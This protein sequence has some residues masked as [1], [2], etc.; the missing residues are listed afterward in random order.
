LF[1]PETIQKMI[2]HWQT[3]LEA[4]AADSEQHIADLPLLTAAEREQIL[5]E[6]NDTK[7]NYPRD[8]CLHELIEG[9][10]QLTPTAAA[11]ACEHKWLSYSELNA[12]ANQ[13]AHHL[14]KLGV[15][16]EVLVGVCMDRSLD[17]MIVLLG[18]MKAGGAYVPLDPAYPK[19]RLEFMIADSGLR[20]IICDSSSSSGVPEFAE[21]PICID[22]HWPTVFLESKQALSTEVQPES[23][24]YVI[25]TS[26]STGRPK[27]VQI[28]HSALVNLVKSMQRRLGIDQHDRLLAVTTISFDIA[29]LEL[30][31]PLTVGA[32]CVIAG[33][34]AAAD[35]YQ[36]FKMF[37][38]FKITAMQATPST[39]KLLLESGWTGKATLKALCGG[40]AMPRELAAQLL[41]RV[42]SVWNMYGPTE[43]TVWSSVH[44]AASVKEAV[45]IGR[46]IDNTE[47]YVLDRN[48]QPLPSG[49][50]GELFIGGDGLARGYLNRPDLEAE[51]FIPNPFSERP[52]ARLYKT[53]DLARYRADGNIE[54]LGRVDNQVKIRGFRVELGEIESVL[55]AHLAITD[56]CV[57]VREDVPGDLRLVA[58]LRLVEKQTPPFADIHN[59]LKERLPGYMIPSLVELD[60]FPLTPNGKLDRLALPVPDAMM[61]MQGCLSEMPQDPIEQLLAATWRELLRVQHIST[62]DNFFDLGGHSLLATQVVAR[63]E[64]EIGLRMKPKEL[65]FQTLGQFAA[66]CKERL[67]RQ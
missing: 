64:K 48:L 38:D 7:V 57:I 10:V 65:A 67:K 26:G 2:G 50:I 62:Y 30:Y 23:L 58:Y 47:I 5:V 15:G 60:G 25:Y 36:L 45:F 39:W 14:R 12:R 51:R 37:E 21:K 19:A 44:R 1:D 55:R 35:G 22:Q 66:S 16:P 4:A 13:L 41:A 11:V 46:P 6:W 17:M 32:C 61:P 9:Q 56:A 63:L 59:F 28:S 52:G 33:R 42:Y 31:L 34:E 43:T 54:C 18:I 29:A 27:G 24:V 40:E 49:I 53:G 3:L 8:R 20:L